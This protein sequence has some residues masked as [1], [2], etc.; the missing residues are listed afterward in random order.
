MIIPRL[1]IRNLLGAGLRTWLNVIVLSFSFVAIILLQ[2]MY[3]GMSRDATRDMI[4]MEYGGGQYWHEKYDPYDPLAIQ[5]AHGLLPARA[6]EWTAAGR[7][8]P[9]LVVQGTVF[10]KGRSVPVLLKGIEPGQAVL[11]IPTRYLAADITGAVPAVIGGRMAEQTGLGLGDTVTVRWRDVH[12]AFDALELE[13]VQVMKTTVSSVDAGQAWVPLEE[14]RKMSRLEGQATLLV[15]A[16]GHPVEDGLPGWIPKSLDVLLEDIREVVRS[17]TAGA[18][19]FYAV[20]LF[21]ALLAVF[22]TQLMSIFHRR[23]EMGTLMALGMTRAKVIQLLTLEGA[24]HSV[25]AA[26]VAAL[27]GIP[28]LIHL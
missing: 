1:A 10:P 7:A 15:L 28:L 12:G 18:T 11:G 27:Y 23:K 6:S 4:E 3:E 8:V 5:D 17:K 19:V 9:I 21:L 16:P 20:L 26:G 22:N 14:L 13:I 24:L 25:L 2:G